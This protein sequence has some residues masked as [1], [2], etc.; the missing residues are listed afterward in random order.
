MTNE[1]EE[2]DRCYVLGHVQ[3]KKSGDTQTVN[4]YYFSVCKI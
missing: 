3:R 2:T 1:S 4:I